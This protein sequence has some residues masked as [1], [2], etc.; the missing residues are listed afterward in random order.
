MFRTRVLLFFPMSWSSSCRLRWLN[1]K[2]INLSIVD[3]HFSV[4]EWLPIKKAALPVDASHSLQVLAKCYDALRL[5]WMI[6][7][8]RL[9]IFGRP[10]HSW[11]SKA[12]CFAVILRKPVLSDFCDFDAD[13]DSRYIKFAQMSKIVTVPTPALAKRVSKVSTSMVHVIE[14]SL[15]IH[16]L[17]IPRNFGL[18]EAIDVLWFGM[19]STPDGATESYAK[20]CSI[21]KNSYSSLVGMDVQVTVICNDPKHAQ[22]CFDSIVGATSFPVRIL[23]WNIPTITKHLKLPGVAII[24]YP[25]PVENCYKSPNRIELAL[26]AGRRV[27]SN[28]ILPS[29]DKALRPWVKTLDN[30]CLQESDLVSHFHRG[31]EGLVIVRDYIDRKQDVIQ[32]QWMFA[33]E[34]L[35]R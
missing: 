14:D 1:I 32:A 34:E 28:G 15:D 9:L 33:L 3:S 12:F 16:G 17:N 27:I 24:P 22:A 2:N 19:A 20:F 21:V 4:G 13:K 11:H 10:V 5:I 25:E 18:L 26:Y 31:I 35:L 6:L 30:D 8:A 7:F 29:L 23:E